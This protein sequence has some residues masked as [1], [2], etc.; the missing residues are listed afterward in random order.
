MN[1]RKNILGIV[2]FG[3]SVLCNTTQAMKRKLEIED[4]KVD[5][6]SNFF[7]LTQAAGIL[8]YGENKLSLLIDAT[9]TDQSLPVMMVAQQSNSRSNATQSYICGRNDCKYS[10]KYKD[11]INNHWA[12]HSMNETHGI[13]MY[14]CD[15]C[16]YIIY[17]EKIMKQHIKIH[18]GKKEEH[19]C[20]LC[21]ASFTSDRSMKRHVFTSQKHQEALL[22]YHNN[23]IL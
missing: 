2:L 8:E 13:G 4:K 20:T 11:R 15:T 23:V 1:N 3:L 17:Q 9:E 5:D 16:H 18:N 14:R 21:N 12:M 19:Y 22:R 10:T 6:K 7:V